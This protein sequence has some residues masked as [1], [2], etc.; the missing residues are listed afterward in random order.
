M[1]PS[2]LTLAPQHLHW[3]QV[4]TGEKLGKHS[5]SNGW[6][7]AVTLRC[8][9]QKCFIK[10]SLPVIFFAIVFSPMERLRRLSQKHSPSLC[11][12]FSSCHALLRHSF[13]FCYGFLSYSKHV[14]WTPS[15]IKNLQEYIRKQVKRKH[16]M[17]DPNMF[18]T[19]L[20]AMFDLLNQIWKTGLGRSEV[21][22]SL[23]AS[24]VVEIMVTLSV[25]FTIAMLCCKRIKTSFL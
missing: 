24:G 1:L 10:G 13:W 19:F 11:Y 14:C 16:L 5:L 22:Y 12:H 9:S 25:K 17:P 7:K 8:K 3:P 18:V 20:T 23:L 4:G 2:N 21:L 6:D 15:I